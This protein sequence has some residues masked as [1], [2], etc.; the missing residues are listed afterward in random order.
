MGGMIS[1]TDVSAG[2]AGW[3]VLE[4]LVPGS[5]GR[6]PGRV[7]CLYNTIQYNLLAII[8]PHGAKQI[9]S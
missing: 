8:H 3:L 1:A 4:M 9:H 6:G 2:R 7:G 5:R